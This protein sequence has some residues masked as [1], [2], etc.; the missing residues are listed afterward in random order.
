[1][2][3]L[4]ECIFEINS[5]T[6]D[7]RHDLRFCTAEGLCGDDS[8]GNVVGEYLYDAWGNLLNADSL[9]EIAKQNPFRY[10]GYYFDSETGMYYLRSRYYDPLVG[11][12]IN[13][14]SRLPLSGNN[15]IHYNVFAY[16]INNPVN[17]YDLSGQWPTWVNTAT[18]AATNGLKKFAVA[19]GTAFQIEVRSEER[20]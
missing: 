5:R 16:S 12:F 13:A 18:R 8:G 6:V 1:M 9:T 20:R 10:R 11:R 14:D 3:V 17:L 2:G 7:R 19:L 4:Y 15:N